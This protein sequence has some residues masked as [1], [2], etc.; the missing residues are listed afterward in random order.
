MA[1]WAC[2]IR[3]RASAGTEGQVGH[4]DHDRDRRRRVRPSGRRVGVNGPED[5]ITDWLSIDW[6]QVEDEVRRLRQRIFT[7]SRNGDLKKVRNLQKLMLRSR[8]NAL[9]SVRR[10]AEINAGRKTAGVDGK[11]ALLSSQKA[12]LADWVQRRAARWTPRPVKRVFIPEANGK[13]RPLG[14]PVIRDRALQAG[15][16]A[17]LEPEW[18]AR[19]E[20]KFTAS[21]RAAAATTRSRPSSPRWWA[22]TRTGGGSST[23]TWQR[24]STGS[25]TPTCSPRWEPS[26][27]GTGSPRGCRPGWSNANSSPRPWRERRRAG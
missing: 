23:P 3:S 8:T 19:F 27:P 14:I 17:A 5:E 20:P 11:T 25:T 24:R 12:G 7:A 16:A 10:V 26:P 2:E 21:A 15:V 18:E 9:L 6:Q 4:N 1:R 13:R 22:A